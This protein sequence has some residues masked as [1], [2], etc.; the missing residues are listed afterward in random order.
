[1]LL[2]V[3][4]HSFERMHHGVSVVGRILGSQIS[5]VSIELEGF[6]LD[7]LVRCGLSRTMEAIS[8][9]SGL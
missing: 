7:L 5:F 9:E 3:F 2:E 6:E 4:G 1:M 8:V